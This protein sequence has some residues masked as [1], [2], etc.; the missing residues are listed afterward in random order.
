MH[1]F[2][3]TPMHGYVT[4]AAHALSIIIGCA[5]YISVS[6]RPVQKLAWLSYSALPVVRWLYLG[7]GYATIL[8]KMS[9]EYTMEMYLFNH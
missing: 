1:R 2:I 3:T 5:I 4:N 6:A 8:L 7:Q 9:S